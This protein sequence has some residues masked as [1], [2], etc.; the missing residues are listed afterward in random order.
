MRPR[1]SSRTE[2]LSLVEV[3][4]ASALL[5]LLSAAVLRYVLPIFQHADRMDTEQENLQRFVLFRSHL[6]KRL[7]NS[8]VDLAGSTPSVLRFVPPVQVQTAHGR[9]NRVNALEMTD[10]D[11]DNPRE[12]RLVGEGLLVDKLVEAADTDPANLRLWEMGEAARLEFDFSA[13]P[14][15]RVVVG[16]RKGHG[17]DAPLWERTF[18]VQLKNFS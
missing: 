7:K 15:V 16:G 17:A 12:I 1:S 2:G 9:L 6:S 13:P 5:L 10:W 4:L 14:L 11:S 3:V 18:T 8:Q